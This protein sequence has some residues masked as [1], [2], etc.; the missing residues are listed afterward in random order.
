MQGLYCGVDFPRLRHTMMNSSF[1][2]SPPG[3]FGQNPD[4]RLIRSKL[5]KGRGD[6]YDQSM[7]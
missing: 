5:L 3:G 7:I 4:P 6:M 2:G 1:S